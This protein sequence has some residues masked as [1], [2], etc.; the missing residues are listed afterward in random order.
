[1]MI[2]AVANLE[3]QKQLLRATVTVVDAPTFAGAKGTMI[4]GV[5]ADHRPVRVKVRLNDDL[6]VSQIFALKE[7]LSRLRRDSSGIEMTWTGLG[8]AAS[9]GR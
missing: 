6:S 4:A 2:Y 1:M 3:V 8:V 9:A 7:A 5:S